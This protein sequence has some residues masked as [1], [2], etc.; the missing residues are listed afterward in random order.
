MATSSVT[1]SDANASDVRERPGARQWWM[2]GVLVLLSALS[3]MDRQV[4]ALMMEPIRLSLHLTSFQVG[5]LHGAAFAFFFAMF[6]MF[7]GWAV[8]RFHRGRIIFVGVMIWSAAATGCGLASNFVQLAIARFSVGAGEAALNPAAYSMISDGFPRH[9]LSTAMGFFG[10][11][12]VIGGALAMAVGGALAATLPPDGATLPLIGHLSQWR[13]IFVLTGVPGFVL[14]FLVLLVR[15][16]VRQQRLEDVPPSVSAAF[17]FLK[18]RFLFFSCF[19]SGVGVVSAGALAML[20][21]MPSHLMRKFGL[22]IAEAGLLLA[23]LQIIPGIIGLVCS[24]MIS[25]FFY[26]RGQRDSNPRVLIV[27]AA[28]Q[29]IPGAVIAFAD[30]VWVCCAAVA[31]HMLV[32]AGN[33]GL[34]PTT[35]QLT[36]PSNFRGQMSGFY[37]ICAYLIGLAFG[38]PLAGALIT[39]VYGEGPTVG[40]SLATLILILNPLAMLLFYI[41]MKEMRKFTP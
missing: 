33:A 24:G 32:T 5:L 21:W 31:I 27:L 12:S 14:A 30:S 7:F 23:P 2:V 20:A 1:A 40:L 16:P 13:L 35:I 37:M 10:T 17:Q 34:G 19:I 4:F 38:P 18:S 9:R 8:D 3:G 29:M 11:G 39:Y 28:L 26:S 15:E 41:A 25:D 22:T 6:G 36:T